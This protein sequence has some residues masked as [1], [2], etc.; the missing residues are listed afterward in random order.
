M[1]GFAVRNIT[2]LRFRTRL[3]PNIRNSELRNLTYVN[4]QL[5]NLTSV[6]SE[7]ADEILV[8]A[9]SSCQWNAGEG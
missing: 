8:A 5:R 2:D 9:A 1:L 4:L 3:K 7:F 6:I